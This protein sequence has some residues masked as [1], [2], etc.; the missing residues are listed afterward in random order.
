MSFSARRAGWPADASRCPGCGAPMSPIELKRKPLGSLT[1]DLCPG[2]QVIWFDT[3]ESLQLTPGAT[4]DLFRAIHAAHRDALR[5]LAPPL[6]C[7]RCETILVPTQDIQHTTR[8]SYYRCR[9]GHGRLT[10]FFQFMREK[11]FIRPIDAREL[12]RL[13]E[14][15][16]TIRCS[17]CGAPVDLAHSANCGYCKSPLM[18]LD[19][20]AV[21]RTLAEFDAA[22]RR[23]VTPEPERQGDAVIALAQLERD[24]AR[25][26]AAEGAGFSADL[27][28]LG[29]AALGR[30][31]RWP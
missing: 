16:K 4:L 7:P 17:S 20:D 21:A 13:A 25:A 11:N 3:F 31:L 18:V 2:C 23:R 8:F 26:R 29:L 22:E 30:F 28:S 5:P 6:T 24:M 10:P 19:P 1:V 12:A 15:V 14:N 9:Y 27:V